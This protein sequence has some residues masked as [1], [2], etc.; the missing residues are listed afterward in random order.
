MQM[1]P[2]SSSKY[3]SR[4]NFLG[5]VFV[6]ISLF[7]GKPLLAQKDAFHS[8]L[9]S[10]IQQEQFKAFP[11]FP[12]GSLPSYRRYAWNKQ[13]EKADVN[14]FFT[15]LVDFTLK[16]IEADLPPDL[17]LQVKQIRSNCKKVYP[18]FANRSGRPT[19]NFWPTDTP[20]I[21]PNGGWLNWFNSTQALPDDMDDTV[22]ILL[23]LQSSDSTAK[24]VHQLMAG[25]ANGQ[26]KSIKNTYSNL[27]HLPAYSTWFGNKMPVDFDICVLSNIL[28][29]VE[30]YR[31]PWQGADSASL[32]WIV[33]VIEEDKYLTEP[34]FIS[35]HYQRTPVIL[36]H[37]S[38]LMQFGNFPALKKLQPRLEQ[39][40]LKAWENST[41]LM[42]ATLLHTALLRWGVQIPY[43]KQMPHS[44]W[45]A[46]ITDGSFSFFIANM[47]SML[48]RFFKK[49]IGSSGAGTFY[50]TCDAYNYAL[51]LENLV[52]QQKIGQKK[53]TP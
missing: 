9:I 8:W 7:V 22:M 21:F 37:L 3:L 34:D 49:T 14:P 27:Q 17:Q 12:N 42:D 24:Y 39:A 18:K 40:A 51:I 45:Q 43:E 6:V 10:Q 38:R 23:A 36:Y 5:I 4:N 52:W 30:Q 15:A 28:Y 11:S 13:I 35:P 33:K 41:H 20:T 50:Y 1:I 25:Y 32:E 46:Q 44:N 31:L 19:Y 53:S 47:S 16:N 29:F 26:K 2:C 48:P